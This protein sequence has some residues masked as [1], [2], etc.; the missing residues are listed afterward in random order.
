MAGALMA[1]IMSDTGNLSGNTVTALDIEA[2]EELA[3]ISS[4]EDKNV[5][6][7]AMSE[8]KLGYYGMTDT[9][10]F[11]SDYKEYACGKYLYGIC[12]IETTDVDKLY[13]LHERMRAVLAEEIKTTEC[14]FLLYMINDTGYTEQYIGYIGKDAEWTESTLDAA[15]LDLAS[16]CGRN[17][18][19]GYY[20]L[21]PSY[22]RK[23]TIAPAL[24]SVLEQE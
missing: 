7:D 2:M 4:I 5:F 10:I 18:N 24:D 9:E 20:I 8:A 23:K 1:G 21:K 13:G 16:S 15:L 12:C 14:D 6:F 3:G 17:E 22:S 19:G 11:Y